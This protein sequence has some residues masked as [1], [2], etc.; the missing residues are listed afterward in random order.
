MF[1]RNEYYQGIFDELILFVYSKINRSDV[2][3]ITIPRISPIRNYFAIPTND[4]F[5]CYTI[6]YSPERMMTVGIRPFCKNCILHRQSGGKLTAIY[7]LRR[8][9][10]INYVYA[11]GFIHELRHVR[12]QEAGLSLGD[13]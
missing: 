3:T 9:S 4:L 8:S 12:K 11:L 7:V 2:E 1:R 5:S 10:N 6:N 13:E